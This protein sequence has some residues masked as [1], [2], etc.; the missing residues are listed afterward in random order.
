MKLATYTFENK[1]AYP[2][3]VISVNKIFIDVDGDGK[4][5]I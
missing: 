5:N 4:R 3:V 1:P 2:I